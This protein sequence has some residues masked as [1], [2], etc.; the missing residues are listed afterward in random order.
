M[1]DN[2]FEKLDAF[3]AKN[4]PALGKESAPRPIKKNRGIVGTSL[5]TLGLA[6]L[7]TFGA[8][9]REKQK[10]QAVEE[11]TELMLWDASAD[12]NPEM[13]ELEFLE[14]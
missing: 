6:T 4:K 1:S 13:E 10:T 7:I 2:Q 5:V 11:F 3:M 14:E 9:E 8:I 12:E